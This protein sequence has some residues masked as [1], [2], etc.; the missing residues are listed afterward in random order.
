MLSDFVFHLIHRFCF[1]R[2]LYGYMKYLFTTRVQQYYFNEI[3]GKIGSYAKD[4]LFT[5]D[6]MFDSF[7]IKHKPFFSTKQNPLNSFFSTKQNP[8]NSYLS[9]F[10][11]QLKTY[12]AI[13]DFFYT[14]KYFF[15]TSVKKKYFI[16]KYFSLKCKNTKLFKK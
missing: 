12:S 7:S 5:S 1:K 15:F 11:K 3:H 10:L 6:F 8:L 14:I 16:N 13:L 9:M 2:I 4:M